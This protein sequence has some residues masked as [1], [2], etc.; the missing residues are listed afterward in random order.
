VSDDRGQ[1]EQHAKSAEPIVLHR[2][3]QVG[4]ASGCWS[5]FV[6]LWG[7]AFLGVGLL[8]TAVSGFC[9]YAVLKDGSAGSLGGMLV[10]GLVLGMCLCWA[11]WF[12][13]R[14]RKL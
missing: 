13:L 11:G 8:I 7:M 14:G 2:E 4:E 3:R 1:S 9:S 12:M 6:V 5:A 10:G